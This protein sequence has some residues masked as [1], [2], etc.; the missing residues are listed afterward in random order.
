MI[1]IHE[2]WPEKEH[3]PH[4]EWHRTLF[5]LFIQKRPRSKCQAW[6]LSFFSWRGN[7]Y[8]GSTFTIPG[9]GLIPQGAGIETI[10]N[11]EGVFFFSGQ[12][13]LA[14]RLPLCLPNLLSASLAE[15]SWALKEDRLSHPDS[16]I[17]VE[18]SVF[19]VFNPPPSLKQGLKLFWSFGH[20]TL[21]HD[22]FYWTTRD[23]KIP[24]RSASLGFR[25]QHRT[26]LV[27]RTAE[28]KLR[29][30]NL[31][32]MPTTPALTLQGTSPTGHSFFHLI[33][34]L[35]ESAQSHTRKH[36]FKRQV[37]IT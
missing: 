33:W 20:M 26:S 18:Q 21:Y 4:Q 8:S 31:E 34:S 37:K 29:T 17:P 22:D 13:L 1:T 27:K 9:S 36:L 5:I 35:G 25:W 6:A 12:G 16:K 7:I 10:T 24:P 3:T 2:L 23:T 19:C 14:G 32:L 28:L 11:L 15:S 30:K